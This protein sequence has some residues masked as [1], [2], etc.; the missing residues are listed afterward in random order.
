MHEKLKHLKNDA[1]SAFNSA[2]TS[3]NE[4]APLKMKALNNKTFIA[5]EFRKEIMKRSKLKNLCNKNKTQENWCKYKIQLNYYV[6]LLCKTKKSNI[7][8]I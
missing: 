2:F 5:K 6:N 7:I 4:Q 1:D 3:L 8:R